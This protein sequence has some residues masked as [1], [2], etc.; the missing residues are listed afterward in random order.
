[1]VN[2]IQCATTSL[3]VLLL[4]LFHADLFPYTPTTFFFF[5][6]RLQS[7]LLFCGSGSG[8]LCPPSL[9]SSSYP[10]CLYLLF[11]LPFFLPFI[12]HTNISLLFSCATHSPVPLLYSFPPCSS[13]LCT[14][15]PV[16][17]LQ[18]LL[19]EVSHMKQRN[20]WCP[21]SHSSFL[22]LILSLPPHL[23]GV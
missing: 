23:S 12:P 19:C 6:P 10:S 5:F 2:P 11:I 4:F 8:L 9:L 13:M 22:L 17:P 20:P 21:C 18:I 14:T 16:F 1:M 3:H 7:L 15:Q